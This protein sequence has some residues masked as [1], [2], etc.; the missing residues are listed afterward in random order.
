MAIKQSAWT[1]MVPVDDTALYVSDS[2]GSGLPV[3]YLNGGYAD[4]SHWRRVIT[5]LGSDYRHITYDERAR[6]KSERSAGYSF[7][8]MIQGLDAVLKARGVDRPLL[9][10]WSLGGILA[11]YWIDRNPNRVQGAVIVDAFPVGV[12]GEA[13]REA[14]RKMFRRWRLLLPLAARFGLGARM[15][16][17]QHAEV[18]IELNEIAAA[19]VPVLERLT[20]PVRFVMATG[21]SLGTSDGEMEQGRTVLD[22][23]LTRNPNLKVSA[24]VASNHT[25]ILRKDSPTVAQA[26]R[27]LAAA[28]GHAVG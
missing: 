21:D 18:A 11:W 19:S 26:I 12:T 3:V 27:E 8:G 13:G 20:R 24:K 6:G 23:I 1:G 2:G 7:G 17:D 16:A 5:D 10:G 9:V 25:G 28:R 4:Q 15:T 22:P 14:I